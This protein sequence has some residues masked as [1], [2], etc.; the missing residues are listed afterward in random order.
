MLHDSAKTPRFPITCLVSPIAYTRF[1][2]TR[3]MVPALSPALV[4]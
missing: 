4:F 2:E 3:D 1:L